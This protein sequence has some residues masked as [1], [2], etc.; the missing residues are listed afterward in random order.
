MET[1]CIRSDYRA[2]PAAQTLVENI[3]QY[4]NPQRRQSSGRFQWHVYLA[5]A[6]QLSRRPGSRFADVGCGYPV[7]I[8]ELI[9]PVC[10][11]ITLFDQPSMSPLIARD[12]STYNFVPLNLEKDSQYP[13]SF[14][15]VVCA[16]VIEHLMDPDPLLRFLESLLNEGGVLLLSTPERDALRGVDCLTSPH[17]EH[18][19]EWAF[20]EF[21]AYLSSRN[22]ELEDHQRLPQK[23]LTALQELLPESI[24]ANFRKTF[25]SCQ[26]AVCR[27]GA[28]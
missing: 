11:D 4:W 19:R 5:A 20:D 7:K 24:R 9:E 23:K 25:L 2:R 17:P 26:L 21:R 14:D 10:D 6:D 28:S 1:Y 27:K 12:F 13:G 16:D 18:V 3:E 15:C 22:V 8:R